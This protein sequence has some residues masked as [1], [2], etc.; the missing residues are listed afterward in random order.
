MH[1]IGYSFQLLGKTMKTD[2][3]KHQ[4]FHPENF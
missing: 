4:R 3:R 2:K 1:F